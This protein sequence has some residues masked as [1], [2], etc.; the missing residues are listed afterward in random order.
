MK[1][2]RAVDVYIA[3]FFIIAFAVTLVAG[4]F[5]WVFFIPS[6]VMLAAYFLWNACRLR[7]PKCGSSTNLDRLLYAR[8]HT[9]HCAACGEEMIVK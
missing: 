5:K 3:Y 2:I 6:A 8:K 4:V 9:Y 7:C 1:L